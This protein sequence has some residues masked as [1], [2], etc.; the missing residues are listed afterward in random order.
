MYGGV[1]KFDTVV[2]SQLDTDEVNL[3]ET[4]ILTQT[5]QY[6]RC[7]VASH[8]SNVVELT[9]VLHN[10]TLSFQQLGLVG[11]CT[12]TGWL[13]Y[14]VMSATL[15]VSGWSGRCSENGEA[16]PGDSDQ[17][18]GAHMEGKHGSTGHGGSNS[19]V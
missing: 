19:L 14:M 15:M 18:C 16:L 4:S 11:N 10:Y 13:V 1:G 7:A 5:A 6:T 12:A 8:V 3:W 2:S 9:G 17:L